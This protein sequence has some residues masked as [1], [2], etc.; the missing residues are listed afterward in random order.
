[1]L[2]YKVGDPIVLAHGLGSVSFVEH[3]DKPFRIAGILEKTGTPVDRT[4]HVSL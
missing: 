1:A 3:G 2:G 4:V